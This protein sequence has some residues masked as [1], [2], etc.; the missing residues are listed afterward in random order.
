MDEKELVCK[1]EKREIRPT[2]L[3]LLILRTMLNEKR[4]VSMTDLEDLLLT[5]DKST[6]FRTITSF[7]SNHLIH[8]IDDGTGS[9]K[10]GVCEDSCNCCINELHPHFYCEHCHRTFCLK[11]D[12]IPVVSVPENFSVNSANYVLK[13][14]C[15]E[16]SKRKRRK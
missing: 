1:L 2:A 8:C 3:R 6:I 5:V 7:L 14:L 12:H 11:N 10:Y 13:G 9:L 16:C 15:S 4:T